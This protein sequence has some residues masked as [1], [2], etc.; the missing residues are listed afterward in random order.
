MKVELEGRHFDT[1]E[2]MKVELQAVL[3]TLTEHNFQ[4]AFKKGRSIGNGSY[5]QRVMVAIRPKVSF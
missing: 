4:D 2:V 3:N 5:G 1:G